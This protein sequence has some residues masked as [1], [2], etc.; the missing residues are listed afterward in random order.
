MTEQQK[1][2]IICE[3]LAENFKN[4]SFVGFYDFRE[5]DGDK[6]K[7]DVIY[8]GEYVSENIFPCGEINLGKG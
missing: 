1:Q 7:E 2:K 5:P 6:Y 8:I 4:W 3:V